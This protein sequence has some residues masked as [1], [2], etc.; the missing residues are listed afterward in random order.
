MQTFQINSRNLSVISQGS[1]H[2]LFSFKEKYILYERLLNTIHTGHLS[3]L[4][5]M[6]K[7]VEKIVYNPRFESESL[8]N[9][10][11]KYFDQLILNVTESCN[12]AC[13]YCIYSGEYNGERTNK[14]EHMTFEIAKHGVD[15]YLEKC[16]DTPFVSFYGGEPT[17]NFDV[18]KSVV[19]Y[20]LSKNPKTLFSMT[21]NFYNTDNIIEK[22]SEIGV[23]ITISLDGPKPTHDKYRVSKGDQPTYDKVTKNLEQLLSLHQSSAKERISLNAT[24]F[25]NEDFNS[26][27]EYF[28]SLDGKFASLK[29]GA[30]ERKGLSEDVKEKHNSNYPII[31]DLIFYGIQHIHSIAEQKKS[32]S[33]LKG[34]F[35]LPLKTIHD[36]STKRMPDLIWLQGSCFPGMRKLFIDTDGQLFTCEKIGRRYTLGDVWNGF[37]YSEAEKLISNFVSIRDNLCSECWLSRLCTPCYVSAKDDSCI[38]KKGLQQTCLSQMSLTLVYITLYTLLVELDTKNVR[39]NYFSK[40]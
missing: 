39:K 25:D 12:L 20:A 26:I 34:L 40:T 1:N 37:Q 27:I 22:L 3:E 16:G 15:I 19:E 17:L 33:V 24:Y 8:K 30:V 14:T 6:S 35:D 7:E 28:I 9:S 38:S 5:S 18:I 4:S 36:R 23:L 29:A 31:D 10:P 32:P 11:K 21:S 13:K 2:I